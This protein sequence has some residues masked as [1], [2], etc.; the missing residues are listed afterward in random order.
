ML[1]VVMTLSATGNKGFWDIL[2]KVFCSLSGSMEIIS[3][4][5]HNSAKVPL[6]ITLNQE[7]D[8]GQNTGLYF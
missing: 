8:L 1:L 3:Q 5:A 4:L 2:M 7:G 6:K